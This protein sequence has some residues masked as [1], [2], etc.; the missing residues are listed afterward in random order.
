M[1]LFLFLRRWITFAAKWAAIVAGV[2]TFLI[3]WVIDVNA[4]TR[5]V[6]NAPL[7]AGVELTQALLPVAIMLPF[8]WALASDN[9]VSSEFLT[10]RLSPRSRRYLRAFWMLVGFMLFA[11]VTY[12]TWQYAMRSYRM[13]EQAWGATLRFPIWPSKMAVSLGTLLVCLQFGVEA[14]ARLI[15]VD[16]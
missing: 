12:G 4:V 6:L 1:S 8:A 16:E 15:G 3:M 9:H 5:K 11:A 7:P 14:V 2:V 10:S 13:G